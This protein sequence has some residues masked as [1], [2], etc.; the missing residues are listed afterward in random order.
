[1][2]VDAVQT[3]DGDDG[4]VLRLCQMSVVVVVFVIGGR[5]TGNPRMVLSVLLLAEMFFVVRFVGVGNGDI[6]ESVGRQSDCGA[7]TMII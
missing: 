6:G 7:V 4:R 5:R 2:V 1:M 3:S